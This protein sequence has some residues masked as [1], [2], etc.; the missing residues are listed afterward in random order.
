MSPV[1]HDAKRTV[2]R[3]R[4]P[5]DAGGATSIVS[6]SSHHESTA[7]RDAVDAAIRPLCPRN[8]TVGVPVDNAGNGT[9]AAGCSR[10]NTVC[11]MVATGR[12]DTNVNEIDGFKAAVG[13]L[14]QR[15]DA[16]S[17]L[18]TRRCGQFAGSFQ[19]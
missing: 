9:A 16:E 3:K 5:K 15:K 11:I 12:G 2:G 17:A 10:N 8:N 7:V 6:I 1:F 4:Q 19:R 13:S 18:R 14:R